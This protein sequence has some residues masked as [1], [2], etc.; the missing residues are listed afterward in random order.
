MYLL[1]L[2]AT[3]MTEV[4]SLG[5]C[6][7]FLKQ[8]NVIRPNQPHYIRTAF[9]TM[10]KSCL[11]TRQTSS[12]ADCNHTSLNEGFCCHFFPVNCS[13]L[14]SHTLHQ[15]NSNILNTAKPEE[16]DYKFDMTLQMPTS[17]SSSRG[18]WYQLRRER[19][20]KDLSLLPLVQQLAFAIL[21][22]S[23]FAD[24]GLVL[25]LVIR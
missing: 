3:D 16:M 15:K 21:S 11:N 14:G 23:K 22:N 8:L 24:T 10:E 7:M 5:N 2:L 6:K 12:N 25:C 17:S 18:K 4:K 13:L 1:K 9:S 20:T 19:K